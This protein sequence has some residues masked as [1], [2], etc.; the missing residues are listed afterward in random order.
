MVLL[1]MACTGS[2]FTS[3][4]S[5]DSGDSGA[6]G[7]SGVAPAWCDDPQDSSPPAGPD[8]YSATLTCGD[9]VEATTAGG[10]S[11]FVTED[12]G[13]FF[14]LLD[15][16]AAGFG[17]SERVYFVDPGD[18][19]DA[20]ATLDTCAPMG[21]SAMRWVDA[22]TCPTAASSVSSCEGDEGDAELSVLFGGYPS[23]NTWAL[24]VDTAG[25][26]AASFRLTITCG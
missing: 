6:T 9:T 5:G 1:L 24:V 22:D 23:S 12:Y 10:Q 11:A 13:H 20:V 21:L 19:V 16:A 3:V 4:D 17:G 2:P 8:C 7:D 15:L 25:V 18:G 26:E 14:C